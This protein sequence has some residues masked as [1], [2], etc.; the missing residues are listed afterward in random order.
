MN[1]ST[2]IT[3][4]GRANGSEILDTVKNTLGRAVQF[5]C[6]PDTIFITDVKQMVIS[7]IAAAD[8]GQIK[9]LNIYDHGNCSECLIGNDLI[10]TN[11]FANFAPHFGK[12]TRLF[13][14]D[15]KVHLGHC[16]MGQN[17]DL[18][19]MFALTFGVKVYAGTGLDAG[20]PYNFNFGEYV[21]V[22]PAG[23]VFKEMHRP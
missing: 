11:N 5:V 10:N 4:A 12:L 15:A 17:T 21:G 1:F 13:T 8:G 16:E 20:A 23:T 19:H 9:R 22:T 7:V 14:K 6:N 18:M 3:V 2:E